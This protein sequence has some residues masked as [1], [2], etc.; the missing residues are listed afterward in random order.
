[1][2]LRSSIVAVVATAF[3]AGGAGVVVASSQFSPSS[4]VLHMGGDVGHFNPSAFEEGFSIGS[5]G[6]MQHSS[7]QCHA[8]QDAASLENLG[9]TTRLGDRVTQIIVLAGNPPSDNLTGDICTRV[10]DA[11][12]DTW[13]QWKFVQGQTP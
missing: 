12:S 13:R 10:G 2:R 5:F 11:G 4:D 1:M 6:F 3:L 8:D 7:E 9:M